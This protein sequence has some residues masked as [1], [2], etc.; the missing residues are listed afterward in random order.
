VFEWPDQLKL[1]KELVERD[2]EV[3]LRTVAYLA[4]YAIYNSVV[5]HLLAHGASV[6]KSSHQAT[7][8]LLKGGRGSKPNFVRR[9]HYLRELRNRAS[10][11]LDFPEGT[12]LK[13]EA[14]K[15][16]K[17]AESMLASL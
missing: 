1:A 2:D 4:Y 15:A 5:A 10:Y 14:Q 16:I 11:D 8:D 7:W 3:A 9:G 12:D 13:L 6:N 17:D